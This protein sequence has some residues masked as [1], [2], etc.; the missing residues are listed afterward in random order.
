MKSLRHVAAA[1]AAMAGLAQAES[2]TRPHTP[3]P[4]AQILA[5]IGVDDTRAQKVV[6]ILQGSRA[7]AHAAREQIGRPTDDTTR[8]TMKAAMDAI[9][10]DTDR[11]LAEV[12]SADELA[13]LKQAM[14]PPP[15]RHPAQHAPAS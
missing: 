10:S 9:R 13:Q 1:I 2:P 3:P 6:A 12:L 4:V 7:K 15:H 14:P 5:G 11:Q 8:A